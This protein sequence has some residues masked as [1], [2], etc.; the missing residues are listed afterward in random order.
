MS[1]VRSR[2]SFVMVDIKNEKRIV[3]LS[4]P[5]DS[6]KESGI[7]LFKSHILWW[8]SQELSDGTG[9]KL[10]WRARMQLACEDAVSVQRAGGIVQSQCPISTSMPT[11]R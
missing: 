8:Y 10:G 2:L 9:F 6:G 4:M 7:T 3:V 11:A 1:D 5:T